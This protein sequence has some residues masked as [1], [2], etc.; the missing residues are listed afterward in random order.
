MKERLFKC[1]KKGRVGPYSNYEWP[2]KKWVKATGELIR[3]KNGIHLSREQDL[4]TWL[5]S[6][7]IWE[8]EYR[9][10]E[11]MDCNDK[12]IVREARLVKKLRGWNKKTIRLFVC[13]CAEHVLHFFEEQCPDDSRPRKAIEVARKYALGKANKE[14]L[15]AASDAAWAIT[16]VTSW[17][18]PWA[19]KATTEAATKAGSWS[20]ARAASWAAEKV[21]T[22]VTSAVTWAAWASW[23]TGT[24]WA[25][26]LAA[27][28]AERKWQI[29]CLMRYL[30]PEGKK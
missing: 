27:Q 18:P 22:W 13:D 14:Q 1:L 19:V 6:E 4:L 11:R 23:T 7:E 17:A 12:I 5:N 28:A 2:V 30:Y 29:G 21:D 16:K 24:S 25:A 20:A 3:C 8:T 10:K 9:G 15:K 26:G